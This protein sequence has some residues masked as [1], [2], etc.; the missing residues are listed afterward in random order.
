MDDGTF[1]E[2]QDALSQAQIT[3]AEQQAEIERLHLRLVLKYHESVQ[4]TLQK[5]LRKRFFCFEVFVVCRIRCRRN[6]LARYACTLF[7]C[8]MS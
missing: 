6:G 2:G 1:A 5:P 7:F 3:L 8:S 4:K